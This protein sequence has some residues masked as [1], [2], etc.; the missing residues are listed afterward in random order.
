MSSIRIFLTG[1]TGN[2]GEY[3]LAE[4]LRRNYTVTAL[5]RKPSDSPGCR[6]VIGELTTI[7]RLGGEIRNA[8]AIIHLAC[9]RTDERERVLREDILGTSLLIDAWRS[10]PFIYASSPTIYGHPHTT[11]REDSTISLRQ[12]YETGKF[13]NELQLRIAERDRPRGPCVRFRPAMLF[14]ASKR[15]HGEQY[16]NS[17][18]QHCRLGSKFVFDSEE[19]LET[20][21]SSFVGGADFA[22]AVAQS[23]DLKV[24]GSYNVVGGFCT[25]R[26]LVETINRIAG[27]RADFLIREETRP[28]PGE[29]RPPQSRVFLDGSAFAEQ[30]GFTPRQGLE[31]L[32]EAFVRVESAQ[33]A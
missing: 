14:T 12:W 7:D 5:V 19:G 27:T 13:S 21:G 6:T 25:W 16:L 32:V 29:C 30:T 28:G 2:A 22:S 9:P 8:D 4:L 17:F 23:L 31:E 1:A 18:Y 3:V 15:R 33:H 10:G 11:V 20:Y 24:G 26:Q